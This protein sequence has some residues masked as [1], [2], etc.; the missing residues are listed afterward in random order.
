MCDVLV[1]KFASKFN[2]HRYA[3]FLQSLVRIALH[4]D[5]RGRQPGE[6]SKFER[7]DGIP[8]ALSARAVEERKRDYPGLPVDPPIVVGF[9]HL[10]KMTGDVR[11]EAELGCL[12]VG[13]AKQLMFASVGLHKFWNAVDP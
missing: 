2:L 10:D 7:Y 12:A 5:L 11:D 9:S 6:M 8:Y 1:S 13:T 4:T 3:E